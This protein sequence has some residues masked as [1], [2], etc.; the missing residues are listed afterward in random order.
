[1]LPGVPAVPGRRGP[2]IIR[3][4]AAAALL[5]TVGGILWRVGTDERSHPTQSV[6]R[7][8][9]GV[10]FAESPARFAVS[11]DG[12]A[13]AM[14]LRSADRIQ[15]WTWGQATLDARPLTGTEGVTSLPAWSPDGKNVA[16]VSGGKLR[17][18]PTAGGPV[19]TIGDLD[20]NAM[21][22][23][24][25]DDTIL[26]AAG[27]DQPIRRIVASGGGVPQ[28][29]TLRLPDEQHESPKFVLGARLFLFFVRSD[30]VRDGLWLGAL[31]G[32]NALKLVPHAVTGTLSGEF[33][34]YSIDQL[35]IAQR[36]DVADAK[37]SGM[38]VTL[39]DHV[40]I[41]AASH[42]LAYSV[43]AAGTVLAFQSDSDG[44]SALRMQSGW[45][46]LVPEK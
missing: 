31:D 16:F 27:G 17:R 4:V 41:E 2:S 40:R 36:F 24:G 34:V 13:I 39:A 6:I 38:P 44:D 10:T 26:V 12:T 42:R 32:G 15:V 35:V 7:L 1:M 43:S 18:I 33:L 11:P 37:F 3:A 29:I 5:A 23:W 28:Q 30:A 45:S 46:A 25:V 14:D 21:F 9:P 8:P 20:A 19:E 22:D